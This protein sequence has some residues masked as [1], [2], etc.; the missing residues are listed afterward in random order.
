MDNAPR[1]QDTQDLFYISRIILEKFL[2][3][4]LSLRFVS[5][6]AVHP[7]SSIDSR[8]KSRFILSERSDLH[9]FDSLLKAVEDV[10]LSLSAR[11]HLLNIDCTCIFIVFFAVYIVFLNFVPYFWMILF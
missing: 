8:K 4:F 2:S 5:F 9:L 3:F 6:Y 1:K 7:Y 10:Q 11:S